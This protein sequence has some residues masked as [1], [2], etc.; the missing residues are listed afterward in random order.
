MAGG[1]KEFRRVLLVGISDR[2]KRERT[3]F[4]GE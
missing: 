4:F 3:I 1:G 2:N